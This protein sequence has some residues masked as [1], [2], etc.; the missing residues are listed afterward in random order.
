MS[1]HYSTKIISLAD[2]KKRLTQKLI[3]EVAEAAD[4]IA[5]RHPEG[6]G[7]DISDLGR[8]EVI[9]IS[10]H[11]G[12]AK[13]LSIRIFDGDNGRYENHVF[14]DETPGSSFLFHDDASCQVKVA[15]RD[16]YLTFANR[17][18]EI[19]EAFNLS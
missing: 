18:P 13:F 17:I 15:D 10:S 11:L 16:H 3:G 4:E 9:S 8:L 7:K 2:H 19:V 6:F 12:K 14:V 5:E 1:Q